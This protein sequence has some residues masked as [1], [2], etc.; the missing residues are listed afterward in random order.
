[1]RCPE[2]S[3]RESLNPKVQGS[4]PC[5]STKH[6]VSQRLRESLC[7]AWSLMRRPAALTQVAPN[8]LFDT[9]AVENALANRPQTGPA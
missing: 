4:I 6:A 2:T 7:G 3:C 5:A 9:L 1:M 8:T